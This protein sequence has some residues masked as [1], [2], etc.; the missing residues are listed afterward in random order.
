MAGRTDR[1][2]MNTE[3]NTIFPAYMLG[4]GLMRLPR[5]DDVIDVEQ[6]AAMA[7]AYLA[8]GGTYF[9]TAYVYGG[10]E[11]AFREAVVKRHKREEFVVANKLP[12]WNVKKPED[13]QTIFEESLSRCGLEYIDYYLLHAMNPERFAFAEEV[14]AWE[15]CKKLKEQGKIRHI[16]FSYHAGPKA[17]DEVL[18]AHPETEFVQLQLNYLDWESSSVRARENYEVCR[19]HGV[20]IIVME[21]VKGGTLANPGEE[22]LEK[23]HSFAPQA[24]AASYALRFVGS[25]PGVSMI[26]SGMSDTAQMNDNLATFTEFCCLS[27]AEEAAVWEAASILWKKNLIPCTA[28]RYCCEGCPMEISIPEMLQCLNQGA[29][30]DGVEAAKTAYEKLITEAGS[31]KASACVQCGQC[32]SAC[33]QHIEIVKLLEKAAK[34]FEV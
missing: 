20:E 28:C 27:E 33:P 1:R 23:F 26:L 18:T 10:S 6:T 9:D 30:T 15:F 3:K 4:F 2:T 14:G 11:V 22:I 24:S 21:P 34:S 17:L 13:M 5:K 25:L 29:S 32:E 19:K 16:G 8:A 31:G 12:L 7:N